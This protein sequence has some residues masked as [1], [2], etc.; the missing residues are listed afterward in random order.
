MHLT[1]ESKSV[2][3]LQLVGD[4]VQSQS[5]DFGPNGAQVEGAHTYHT[6]GLFGLVSILTSNVI[7]HMTVICTS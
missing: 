6:F 1:P 3:D 7:Y 5:I 2:L 4:T